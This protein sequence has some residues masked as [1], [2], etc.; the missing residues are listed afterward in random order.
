MILQKRQFLNP[1]G[2]QCRFRH[3]KKPEIVEKKGG[4]RPPILRVCHPQPGWRSPLTQGSC[5]S[6]FARSPVVAARRPGSVRIPCGL[7][8]FTPRNWPCDQAG[9]RPPR[10]TLPLAARRRPDP[11]LGRRCCFSG[12]TPF[13][14]AR[15]GHRLGP[16]RQRATANQLRR[17]CALLPR[18]LRLARLRCSLDSLLGFVRHVVPERRSVLGRAARSPREWRLCGSSVPGRERT[19]FGP[20]LV[21]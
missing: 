14:P 19:L 7:T 17:P 21:C 9:Y 4:V 6:K 11:G 1:L 16:G 15:K 12:H 3:A 20:P 13:P 10:D 5:Q 8:I 18:C 2:V